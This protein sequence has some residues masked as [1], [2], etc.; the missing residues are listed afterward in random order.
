M[1]EQVKLLTVRDVAER[2]HISVGTA[3]N[4]LSQN[5]PMPPSLRVGRRRLFPEREFEA[6][7]EGI[8]KQDPSFSSMQLGGQ[9]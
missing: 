4:R 9:K 7:L 1:T 6:W 5:F 8:A 3:R 2:L